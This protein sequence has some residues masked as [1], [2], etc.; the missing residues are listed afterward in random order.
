VKTLR[1]LTVLGAIFA[2]VVDQ[3]DA[4]KRDAAAYACK[5]GKRWDHRSTRCAILRVWAHSRGKAGAMRVA[6]CESGFD[7]YEVTGQFKGVYQIGKAYHPDAPR[8][9]FDPVASA[10]W[11]LQ[12]T[13][14]GRDW[15]SWQ[16][17]WAA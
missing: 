14:G 3:A 11:V 12:I 1:V 10:R 13:R 7:A 8:N 5:H 9:L 2:G 16:C 17:G 6:E 15:S 4:G